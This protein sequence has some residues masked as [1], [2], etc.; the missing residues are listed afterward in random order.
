MRLETRQVEVG[1]LESRELENQ[2]VRKRSMEERLIPSPWRRESGASS[3]FRTAVFLRCLYVLR[4]LRY[5]TR[6][7]IPT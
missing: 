4:T 5:T 7:G 6:G 1:G 2:H 3:L